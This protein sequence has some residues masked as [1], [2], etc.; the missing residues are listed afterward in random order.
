MYKTTDRLTTSRPSTSKA[1]SRPKAKS[2][3]PHWVSFRSGFQ[4]LFKLQLNRHVVTSALD[5][6]KASAARALVK[7]QT[8]SP[9]PAITEQPVWSPKQLALRPAQPPSTVSY[10]PLQLKQKVGSHNAR[11]PDQ[12]RL[13]QLSKRTSVQIGM[14]KKQWAL[15]IVL[16]AL[17]R[18]T[19]LRVFRCV[20][21]WSMRAK[22][23]QQTTLQIDLLAIETNPIPDKL[24]ACPDKLPSETIGKERE[25]AHEVHSYLPQ[26][27][28]LRLSDRWSLRR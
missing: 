17:N 12:R 26:S 21:V 22:D 14:V 5:Q 24:G 19:V 15:F 4:I 10:V 23:Q 6:W 25:I 16:E 18:F 13:L 2:K 11:L 9:A 20:I 27:W 28:Q 1:S 7:A 3:V 8:L